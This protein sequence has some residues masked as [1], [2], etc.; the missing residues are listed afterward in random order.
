MITTTIDLSGIA[1]LSQK[2]ITLQ[3][4]D[5]LLRDVAIGMQA[6]TRE[7]I[8]EKGQKGDGSQIGEYKPSYLKL[9]QSKKY[10]RTADKTIVL[11]LT[12][13]MENDYKV[14]ALSKNA[15]ALGFDNKFNADK[16]D[17]NEKRFGKVW[18]LTEQELDSVRLIVQDFIK[19]N[20][21]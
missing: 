9:R 19:R 8:H 18:A 11:S 14:I 12:R 2:F 4:A 13:Q 5:T 20:F 10:N 16:A 1:G 17:W 15:Y 6:E 21:E 3:Q 7:R